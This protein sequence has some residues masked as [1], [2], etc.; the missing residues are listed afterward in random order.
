MT[1]ALVLLAALAPIP[2]VEGKDGTFTFH[3]SRGA[4]G[5]PCVDYKGPDLA[6]GN[7]FVAVGARGGWALEAV[8]V[9]SEHDVVFFGAAIG[10]ARE[11][12]IGKVASLKPLRWSKRYHLRFFAGIAP[13]RATRVPP[14]KI[15]ALDRRSRL[16]GRQHWRDEHGHYGRCDGIWDRRHCPARPDTAA[17]SR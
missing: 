13:R 2:D 1:L 4:N 5:A 17:A 14:N 8:Y 11:V 15:V 10:R 3:V 7:C 16:L 9:E 12:R 6:G